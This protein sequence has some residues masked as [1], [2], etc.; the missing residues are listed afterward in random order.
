MRKFTFGLVAGFAL[1]IFTTLINQKY[2]VGVHDEAY[3]RV[4][5]AQNMGILKLQHDIG[6]CIQA[7]RSSRGS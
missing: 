5:T 2:V 3:M 6:E 4:L 1:G 7:L